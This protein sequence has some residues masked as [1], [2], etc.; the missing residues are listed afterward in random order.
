[1]VSLVYVPG[2]FVIA[3][4]HGSKL[5]TGSINDLPAAGHPSW[6]GARLSDV[7]DHITTLLSGSFFEVPAR[8]AYNG[9]QN[10]LPDAL[11]PAKIVKG[12]RYDRMTLQIAR[13]ALASGGSAIDVGAH[14]GDILRELVKL[15]PGPH[16]AFEPIPAFASR[17]RK[18][19]PHVMIEQVAA[20]DSDGNAEFHFLPGAAAY[21]SL[22]SRPE[23]EHGRAV[24]QLIVQ[25]R[26]LDDCIPQEA[27]VAF[28]KMDVEGAE[29]AVLRGA[30]HLLRRC[31][32][33]VVFECASA[34]LPECATAL[35]ESELRIS[36]LA[37]FLKDIQRPQKDVLRIG[38]EDGEYYYVAY[39]NP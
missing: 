2:Q 39:R 5:P 11:L 1:M 23:I 7:R 26:R 25:M 19:F 32:P 31:Q 15:S 12:R 3:L 24:R 9:I 18:R 8:R 29:A 22:L 30:T 6:S 37:D 13:I 21:S 36:F 14:E 28:I 34:R 27:R 38:R 17:L 35:D 10:R 20:S 16:W 4:R 33:I